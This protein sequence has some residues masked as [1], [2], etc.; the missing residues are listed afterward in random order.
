MEQISLEAFR[1]KHSPEN[2]GS[3]SIF[4]A[5]S[6][7]A[8]LFLL[9]RGKICQARSGETIFEYGD[10]GDSFFIV[11]SGSLEFF[12]QH[13][14]EYFQTRTIGF[15]EEVGFVAM[16]A[17]HEHVGNAVAREDSLLLEV[18]SA[19]FGQLHQ[20]YPLD[21]GLL[22]LN[23]ARDMAR[24]IRKLGNKLVENAIRH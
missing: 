4:G 6:A 18:N 5:L 20:S 1:L 12:K 17:L 2:L 13:Q 23:L 14:G 8:T 9:E 16:I 24:V 22:L 19:L 10:R 15:G 21:F 11:C 7:D 3:G